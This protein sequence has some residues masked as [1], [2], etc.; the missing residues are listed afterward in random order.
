[1][2][3]TLNFA[4]KTYRSKRLLFSVLMHEDPLRNSIRLGFEDLFPIVYLKLSSE[5]HV[6]CIASSLPSSKGD[7][8]TEVFAAN[9]V[10]IIG[11][12]SFYSSDGFIGS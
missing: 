11:L 4:E 7:D 6:D 9:F 3:S 10:G 5:I 2:I 1:M 12:T 8:S